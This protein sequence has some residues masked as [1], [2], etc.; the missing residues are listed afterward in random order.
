MR[1]FGPAFFCGSLRW[2]PRQ[3]T[4][5]TTISAT[6]TLNPENEELNFVFAPSPKR[7]SLISLTNPVNVTGTLADPQVVVTILPRNRTA[8]SCTRKSPFLHLATRP[9][10]ART[11][12]CLIR[13]ATLLAESFVARAEAKLVVG[14]H[15]KSD[16]K[17]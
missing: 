7:A 8:S 17:A 2:F 6:S 11:A 12:A 10:G 4:N 1:A 13:H 14:R 16:G 5:S 9:R 3:V 15:Q